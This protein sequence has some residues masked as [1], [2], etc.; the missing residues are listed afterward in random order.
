[1]VDEAGT[2]GPEPSLFDEEFP[3]DEPYVDDVPVIEVEAAVS[4]S[5]G[6]LQAPGS[7]D[8][9]LLLEEA[10]EA[11]RQAAE[12]LSSLERPPDTEPAPGGAEDGDEDEHGD[13]DGPSRR[14]HIER[15]NA[16]R[17]VVDAVTPERRVRTPAE[18][19]AALEAALAAQMPTREVRT[20]HER[21]RAVIEVVEAQTPPRDVRTPERRR[22][23]LERTLEG[24]MRNRQARTDE[25][26]MA[27]AR[28]V[29]QETMA[30]REAETQAL[31]ARL[32]AV[33]ADKESG[34]AQ[35]G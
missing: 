7:P 6:D 15:M 20:D 25:E 16:V 4:P 9:D 32:E 5:G 30:A 28:R 18:R 11:D 3:I 8:V 31:R 34:Q 2:K 19:K 10:A 17:D 1:M 23:D 27:D 35:E 29:A 24:L 33:R 13:G 22:K 21:R 26:R 14:T 12:L